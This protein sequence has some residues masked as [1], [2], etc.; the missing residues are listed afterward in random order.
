MEVLNML[1]VKYVIQTNKEGK[2]FPTVNANANGNAWFV[3]EV[4]LVNKANDEMK[5]LDYLNTKKV[6]VFNINLYGDKFK[7]ARLKRN[8]DTTGTI[9]LQVYKPN[10]IRYS[11]NSKNEG[12]AV[13]SEIYYEKGWNAYVDGE[14]TAH[15]PVDYVLRAM[16]IPKGEHTVE[17]KFEPE[18]IKTGSIITLISAAGM[19][20]LL[21]GG[22]YYER[23]KGSEV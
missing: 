2:E 23:K 18:V 7:N 13:F 21:V 11:S 15:F 16:M 4:K 3:N 10:Y 19:L 20:L 5:A 14:K 22:I 8:L 12:L 17:F 1:N 9:K 6:A